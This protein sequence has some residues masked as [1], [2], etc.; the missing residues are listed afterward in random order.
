MG[1]EAESSGLTLKKW[2]WVKE[3]DTSRGT[4]SGKEVVRSS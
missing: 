2:E 4:Y 1:Y 3:V